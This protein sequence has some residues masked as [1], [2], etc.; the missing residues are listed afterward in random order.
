[1]RLSHVAMTVPPGTLTE[2]TRAAIT[3]FYGDLLG[4][5]EMESLRLPDRLTLSV[6][7]DD[8]VNIRERPDPMVVSGYEHMGVVVDSADQADELWQRLSDANVDTLEPLERRDDGYRSFRFR[9]LLPLS[10]EVH[11]F[12]D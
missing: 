10:I 11:H 1:M 4:W 9:H 7:P 12:P 2:T 8:W 6:G 3:S 5:R